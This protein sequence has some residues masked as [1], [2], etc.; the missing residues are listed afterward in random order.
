[1][2]VVVTL[3]AAVSA[4]AA[5][6]VT[7]NK[8]IAPI[9]FK[10][11]S[12]C[13]RP[14]EIGPFP[15]LHYSDVRAHSSQITAVT[16][17]R[18]M[19]PWPPAHGVGEFKDPRYLTQQQI[20]L[21]AEW[22]KNGSPEGD[23]RDLP[24]A[25][26]YTEGWQLGPP[27]LVVKMPRPFRL[28]AGGGDVFRNFVVPIDIRETKYVRAVELRPG[29]KR[30]VHHANIVI[31][32]TRALRRR[33][34]LDGQPGFPGMDVTT[35]SGD[36]FDPDSHFLFWK[37]GSPPEAEPSDMAWR[38]DPGT[39]L[40]INLHLQ[41][42]GKPEEIQPEIGLYFTSEAP[43]RLPMLLQLEHDGAIDIAPGSK[44]SF[45]T[46]SLRMPVDVDVLA[47]YPHAH[48]LGKQIEATA[49]LPDG[50]ERK[51]I[52]IDDWDINWQAVYTYREPVHL[53]KGTVVSMRVTYD[54]TTGNVR[55]PSN[56]PKRVRTGNRS[57]DEMGHVWLQVLPSAANGEDGRLSL[58]EALMRRRLEKYPD[59]FVA[60]Y[61]LGALLQGRG[62]SEEA[63]EYLRRAV[64]LEPEHAAA[65]NTFGAALLGEGHT[66]QAVEQFRD[67]IALDASYPEPHLNLAAVYL[68]Q[69]R[70]RDALPEFMAAAQL[71]PDD[72]DVQCNLGTL[73]AMQHDLKG[74]AAAFQRALALNPNQATARANLAKAEAELAGKAR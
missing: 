47:I 71:K 1:M 24:P 17:S 35:E 66:D 60:D 63:V 39:D 44:A 57:E 43:T 3:L 62:A 68:S 30:L 61:N 55:N 58:Q 20:D 22:V 10:N 26:Q 65:H 29:S 49:K 33:D 25:P 31:D 27:D 41:P 2:K 54:N 48:Y 42:S 16:H 64:K 18:Y 8:D 21:I 74:A 36:A 73:L 40:V 28:P 32:R 70:F 23:A 51:L 13:H 15:L 38:L 34:G 6:P 56:S 50:T 14:G 7:F 72:A 4:L 11:C 59:D 46:D 37:P 5:G 9:V 19:P 69:S 67:A 45:I 12:P 52:R 53:P